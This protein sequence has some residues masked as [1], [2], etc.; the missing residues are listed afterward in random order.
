MVGAG[1]RIVLGFALLLA[2]ALPAGADV[3]LVNR[4]LTVLIASTS[5]R[6]TIVG[7]GVVIDRDPGP[8][9]ATAAHLLPEGASTTVYAPDGTPL[10]VRSIERVPGHDL[11]IVRTQAQRV[12]TR[13]AVL[14]RVLAGVN[15]FLWGH[16][17][18]KPYILARAMVVDVEP[19]FVVP[20]DG[21]FTIACP[22]CD[23]GDSGAAVFDEHGALL[24][25]LT[26]AVVDPAGHRLGVWIAEPASAIARPGN[27][28]QNTS[29]A[30]AANAPDPLSAAALPNRSASTPSSP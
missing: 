10:R 4:D 23:L 16:P 29:A 27:A 22:T 15:A 18:G 28:N 2:S 20:A 26:G 9:V 12:Q 24:G 1:T 25:I 5:G 3:T 14:G 13:V 8:V 19:Q 7:A 17:Q 11:A 30:S 6:T 21:R